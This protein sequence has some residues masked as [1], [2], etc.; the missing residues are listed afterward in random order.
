[1]PTLHLR[2]TPNANNGKTTIKLSN[3]L[4][5]QNFHLHSAIIVK[6]GTGYNGGHIYIR[7][8]FAS[9]S[10]FHTSDKKGLL[11]I[12]TMPGVAGME[13]HSFSDGL[14]LEVDALEEEFVCELLQNDL[15]PFT[16]SANL[17]SVDL[18]FGYETHS[19][20]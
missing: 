5:S 16:S 3:P 11:L 17:K 12:P 13:Q 20:F 4:K 6:T 15:T 14:P 2:L 10:Q 18:Y 19:L 1:M 9:A 7:L 8:P